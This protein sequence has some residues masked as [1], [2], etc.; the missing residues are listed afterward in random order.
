MYFAI[1][2]VEIVNYC[3]QK[4]MMDNL[5]Y[6]YW[7][8]SLANGLSL[9]VQTGIYFVIE[10]IIKKGESFNNLSTGYIVFGFIINI[11]LGFLQYLSRK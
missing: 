8:I 1:I 10:L 4:Y 11:I 9:F 6:Q 5:Y 7:N 3:Y 2:L